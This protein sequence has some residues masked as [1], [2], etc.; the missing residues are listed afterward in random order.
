MNADPRCVSFVVLLL[1]LMGSDLQA[2]PP[3]EAE[4]KA[5]AAIEKMGGSKVGGR[6]T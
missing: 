3:D 4:K 1:A 5:I 6:W 2:E